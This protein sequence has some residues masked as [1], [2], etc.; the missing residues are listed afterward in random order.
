[1]ACKKLVEAATK[2]WNLEDE[3]VDDIT[4]VVVLL[5]DREIALK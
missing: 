1:M 5:N 4:C 3:V 2:Q